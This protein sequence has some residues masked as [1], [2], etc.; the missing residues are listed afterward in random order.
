MFKSNLLQKAVVTT[1]IF[2]WSLLSIIFL[3]FIHLFDI[4]GPVGDWGWVS[5]FRGFI[6]GCPDPVFQPEIK[7]SVTGP[8]SRFWHLVPCLCQDAPAA[9]SSGFLALPPDSPHPHI[10]AHHHCLPCVSAHTGTKTRRSRRKLWGNEA[11]I[12]T[13]VSQDVHTLQVT[14]RTST[15]GENVTQARTHTLL[16]R[17]RKNIC[18]PNSSENQSN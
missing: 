3:L 17:Q 2:P 7:K 6:P 13:L 4:L 12:Q 9:L 10:N 11:K 18:H 15:Y 16:S 5:S 1:D 8:P 14:Q